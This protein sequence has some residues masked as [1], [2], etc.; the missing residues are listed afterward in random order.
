MCIRDRL[1][2]EFIRSASS[3]NDLKTNEFGRENRVSA[4]STA[5][6]EP[7]RRVLLRPRAPHTSGYSPFPPGSALLAQIVR[8]IPLGLVEARWLKV[9]TVG[10]WF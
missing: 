4:K 3:T 9:A 5:S 6:T 1:H 7:L 10:F 8:F 2:T